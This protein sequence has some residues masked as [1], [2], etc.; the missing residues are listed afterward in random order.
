MNNVHL[1]DTIFCELLASRKI[2]RS[3]SRSDV[4][5]MSAISR[6]SFAFAFNEKRSF[7]TFLDKIEV[8]KILFKL[9]RFLISQ[10]FY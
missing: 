1:F 8:D 6:E 9:T 7:A 4:K 5:R 3:R 10:K 2:T